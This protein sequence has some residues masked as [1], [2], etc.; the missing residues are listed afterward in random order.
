MYVCL[1]V[2]IICPLYVHFSFGKVRRRARAKKSK[3]VITM[4][5]QHSSPACRSFVWLPRCLTLLPEAL[6]WDCTY[7]WAHSS[8]G[9]ILSLLSAASDVYYI[10]L[11]KH[12]CI[13]APCGSIAR[14]CDGALNTNAN[15]CNCVRVYVQVLWCVLICNAVACRAT[16]LPSCP[17]SFFSFPCAAFV[18]LT[19][20]GWIFRIY[21]NA[22]T[23]GSIC[24]VIL[25]TYVCTRVC[26]RV[27]AFVLGEL[28]AHTPYLWII[29]RYENSTTNRAEEQKL[30]PQT[31]KFVIEFDCCLNFFLK[32]SWQPVRLAGPTEISQDVWHAI[33]IELFTVWCLLAHAFIPYENLKLW[34]RVYSCGANVFNGK[35]HIP[36]SLSYADQVFPI[37]DATALAD[38]H[39]ALL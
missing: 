29:Y 21:F 20:S 12:I 28:R 17:L 25:A 14:I 37:L 23:F 6:D 13:Y 1:Y 30:R 39:T 24:H 38:Q 26:E 36:C 9:W 32:K 35:K 2:F 34:K 4:K 7:P 8:L 22:F 11:Y 18:V 10:A 3:R 15:L 31:P 33:H 27:L 19:F 5:S 16:L